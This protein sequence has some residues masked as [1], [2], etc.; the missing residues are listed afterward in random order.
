METAVA[1]MVSASIPV[2]AREN[3]GCYG[4]GV[5]DQSVER[6]YG[7]KGEKG[8]ENGDP[9]G[10][11]CAVAKDERYI[12]IQQQTPNAQG[13]EYKAG[14]EVGGQLCRERETGEHTLANGDCKGSHGQRDPAK[15]IP[16]EHHSPVRIGEH[17]GKP[18]PAAP[19]VISHGGIGDHSAVDHCQQI[20][21]EAG[22]QTPDQND[23][24]IG[25]DLLP[26][27]IPIL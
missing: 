11:F 17:P 7:S 3:C 16:A 10:L 6:T 27:Y 5:I 9:P 22:D 2:S 13:G 8:D 20:Q 18:V 15:R 12:Q 23:E 26:Q 24:K 4:F 14:G 21:S 25:P 1:M 19:L